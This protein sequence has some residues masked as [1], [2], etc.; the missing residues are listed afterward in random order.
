VEGAEA[1]AANAV[2]M[3]R[4]G[5]VHSLCVHGDSPGAVEAAAAVRAA[6]A[7]AGYD[8]RAW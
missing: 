6:L 3:A 7:K 2:E 1:I 4:A 8:V 5:E